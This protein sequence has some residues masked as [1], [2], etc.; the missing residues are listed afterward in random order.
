MTNYY[1]TFFV[2]FNLGQFFIRQNVP[3]R[4]SILFFYREQTLKSRK[5]ITPNTEGRNDTA[6]LQFAFAFRFHESPRL[7]NAGRG[8][9]SPVEV[10]NGLDDVAWII[11][12]NKAIVKQ[13]PGSF[14]RL[15]CDQTTFFDLYDLK[16][17]D[18]T[19]IL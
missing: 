15:L 19:A 3:G 14:S 7:S 12:R 2:L 8:I 1:N 6:N 16:K 17:R 5:E 10:T 11:E 9:P 4:G 13:L 18:Q